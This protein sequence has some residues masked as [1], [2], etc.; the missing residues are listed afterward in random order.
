MKFDGLREL[1]V[2][3]LAIGL[4]FESEETVSKLEDACQEKGLLV[5]DAGEE[6]LLLLPPL[7]IGARVADRGLDIL[8]SC[9]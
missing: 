1:R 9:L 4:E 3:G 8:E 6:I 2:Q 7:T 5:T